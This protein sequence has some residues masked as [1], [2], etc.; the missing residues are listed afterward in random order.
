MSEI[1]AHTPEWERNK[2]EYLGANDSACILDNGYFDKDELINRKIH[3]IRPEFSQEQL[4]LLNRG[5]RYESVVRDLCAVRNGVTMHETGQR[6]HPIYRYLTATPDG[7][8]GNK[9]LVEF[10]VRKHID[11]KISFKYWIQMQ[12][13]MEVWN[14]NSCLFCD[15]QVYE[16]ADKDEYIKDSGTS[17][18][19]GEIRYEGQVYYWKLEDHYEVVVER[20]R[21]WFETIIP[22]IARAWDIILYG[23]KQNSKGKKRKR[24]E[25]TVIADRSLIREY[26]QR[27]RFHNNRSNMITQFD[28]TNWVLNDPLLDWLNL[29]GDQ[30][31]KDSGEDYF[32]LTRYIYK[33]TIEFR[34]I[35]RNYLKARTPSYLYVDIDQ[36]YHPDNRELPINYTNHLLYYDRFTRTKEAIAKNVPIIFNAG[37]C[38][39]EHNLYGKADLIVKTD[40]LDEL[41]HIPDV[42]IKEEMGK[43]VVLA[44]TFGTL[45]LKSNQINLLSNEK[46]NVYKAHLAFLNICLSKMQGGFTMSKS[47]VLGRRSEY[48]EK[49]T[50]VKVNNCFDRAGIV[51]FTESDSDYLL[52]LDEALCWNAEIRKREAARWDIYKPNRPELYPNMKNK[53]DSPWHS[54]KT[55]LAAS[56]KEITEMY[57]CGVKK[58]NFALTKEINSWEDLTEESI[59]SN[60]KQTIKYITTI[61]KSNKEDKL[62]N[63]TDVKINTEQ[64]PTDVDLVTDMPAVEFYVDFESANGLCDDLKNFPRST[65]DN[66]I[67]IIGS[68]CVNNLTKRKIQDTFI[69]DRLNKECEKDILKRWI[70]SMLSLTEGQTRNIYIYHWGNAEK[71]ML[72]KALKT[73][74]MIMGNLVL[75]DLC[76]AFKQAFVSLPCVY[77]YSIKDIGKALHRMGKIETVWQDNIDGSSA[78]VAA[79]KAESI[80]QRDKCK[81]KDIRFIA[82]MIKYNY[83]DCKVM[84][85]IMNYLRSLIEL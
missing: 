71:W 46:Q 17:K 13:Q 36:F 43:Y 23:R 51:D 21:K 48:T 80:C 83:I 28:I 14:K 33:K 42:F 18:P 29:Y 73:H 60:G 58:R 34:A 37:L 61:I 50:K 62:L 45:N 3:Y 24:D 75:I 38:D 30:S 68:L 15:N 9:R 44:T 12:I 56:Q 49:K 85:E 39:E 82:D 77:S 67:Y 79:W 19:R 72:E 27:E 69:V 7:I 31:K 40:F 63:V 10:K 16:Y 66:I 1:R 32:S 8:I 2:I 74:G 54:F 22:E 5:T 64:I 52:K 11:H 26:Y 25:E 59:A 78:M 4:K 47:I 55:E 81:F 57:R 6:F 76:K 35:F 84:E 41:M 65:T 53:R 20:D 70:D